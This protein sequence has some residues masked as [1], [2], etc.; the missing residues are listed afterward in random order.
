MRRSLKASLLQQDVEGTEHRGSAETDMPAEP[1]RSVG[2]GPGVVTRRA[3]PTKPRNQRG[4]GSW[5]LASPASSVEDWLADL[6]MPSQLR[7]APV[8]EAAQRQPAG[9]ANGASRPAADELSRAAAELSLRPLTGS[10]G[11][12]RQSIHDGNCNG[13]SATDEAAPE[14]PLTSPGSSERS[15]DV[16]ARGKQNGA[17][18]AGRLRG[19]DRL[20]ALAA[21]LAAVEAGVTGDGVSRR[22]SGS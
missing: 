17:H 21:V 8:G 16:P 18:G 19:E 3:E 15:P 6:P 22:G 13:A 4:R 10:A 11:C 1:R 14:G 12:D 2:D 7:G 5:Q 9:Q 20:E